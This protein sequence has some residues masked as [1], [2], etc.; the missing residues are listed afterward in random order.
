MSV[1][2][3]ALSSIAQ[4]GLRLS[5]APF[6]DVLGLDGP[7]LRRTLFAEAN[8]LLALQTVSDNPSVEAI[9]PTILGRRALA[10]FAWQFPD[11]PRLLR[12][13]YRAR[14]PALI[15]WGERDDCVPIMHGHAFHHGIANSEFAVIADA[16][17]LP[18]L[19]TPEECAN[20]VLHLCANVA[21]NDVCLCRGAK[22][23]MWKRLTSL[24]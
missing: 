4:L 17:H 5:S 23:H 10:R 13:L 9:V 11:D 3:P 19:E 21:A 20:L 24:V 8:S 7:T 18:H 22:I 2:T 14:L 15:L 6:A 1:G 16:G 12:Y